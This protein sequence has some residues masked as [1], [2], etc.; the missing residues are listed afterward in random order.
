MNSYER[1]LYAVIYFFQEAVLSDGWDFNHL[2]RFREQTTKSQ[3]K[4][5]YLLQT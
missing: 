2:K 5:G 3:S 4:L 1:E